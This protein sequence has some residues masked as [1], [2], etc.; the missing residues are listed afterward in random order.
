MSLVV[1]PKLRSLL[2]KTIRRLQ[3]HVL[4]GQMF[5]LFQQLV[6]LSFWQVLDDIVECDQIKLSPID[7][8]FH[9]GDKAKHSKGPTLS[10]VFLLGVSFS[11][12]QNSAETLK[13]FP[14]S[15][16]LACHPADCS[17]V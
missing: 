3:Q 16:S 15:S 17:R 11:I 8:L 14:S 5:T 1:V 7:T 2:E 10:R 12:V 4:A 9:P 13:R 6:T